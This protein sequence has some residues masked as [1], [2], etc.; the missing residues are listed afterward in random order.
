[1]QVIVKGHHIHI[2]EALKETAVHKLERLARFYDRIQKIEVDFQHEKSARAKAKHRVEVFITTA[3]GPVRAHAKAED[4]EVALDVVLGKLETQVKR[5]KDKVAHHDKG[6]VRAKAISPRLGK[7]EPLRVQ[8]MVGNGTN[9]G[10]NGEAPELKSAPR[11]PRQTG[12][13]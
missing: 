5:L 11:M 1:M 4:P 6:G 12:Q 9:D 8:P 2:S 7:P 3:L 10:Q 13:A